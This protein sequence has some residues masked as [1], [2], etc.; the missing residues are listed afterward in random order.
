MPVT[1]RSQSEKASSSIPHDA[2]PHSAVKSSS[3]NKSHLKSTVPND[4]L[5]LTTSP[6]PTPQPKQNHKRRRPLPKKE[7]KRPFSKSRDLGKD[8]PNQTSTTL[9]PLDTFT[10]YFCQK[11]DCPQGIFASLANSCVECGHR[12]EDH[13][14]MNNPWYPHPTCEYICERSDLVH[15][16]LQRARDLRVVVIRSIPG[17]G[18]SVL[19]KL[20]GYH[21]HKNCP[22]LEPIFI[23][24]KTIKERNNLE[25]D[26]YLQQE[27]EIWKA[28]NAEVRPHN[29]EATEIF[30]IDE[31]QNSYEDNSFWNARLKNMNLLSQPK[32]IIASCL[33]IYSLPVLHES[34]SFAQMSRKDSFLYLELRPSADD[35]K[36]LLFKPVETHTMII[37]WATAHNFQLESGVSEYLHAVTDGHVRI[38]GVILEILKPNQKI[39]HQRVVTLGLC[40]SFIHDDNEFLL[41]MLRIVGTGFWT[42]NVQALVRQYF[43]ASS[44]YYHIPVSNIV[45]A[46]R[47]VARLPHGYTLPARH[48]DDRAL[49]F[50]HDAGLL[51]TE[52]R[53]PGS[54]E[55]TYFFASPIHRTI[56]CR[57]LFAASEPDTIQ[58]EITLQQTCFNAIGRFNLSSLKK[59]LEKPFEWKR[60]LN[61]A[62][63]N[64]MYCCLNPELHNIEIISEYSYLTNERLDFYIFEKKWGIAILQCRETE[65]M[66]EYISQ[67]RVGGKYHGWGAMDDFIILTFWWRSGGHTLDIKDVDIQS[68]I[69]QVAIDFETYTVE[70]YTYDGKLQL[71][72]DLGRE[73][74]QSHSI[75]PDTN[76]ES[77]DP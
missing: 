13:H 8:E 75:G 15:A 59:H 66:N 31:G 36:H 57:R 14:D 63:Q 64:E 10:H 29:P 67:F 30:L 51:H 60:L 17:V 12:F 39:N 3:R 40:Y 77:V 71:T 27:T 54:E 32:F 33:D 46:L 20:L 41:H 35:K 26:K 25:Y 44:S 2:E 4:S 53:R 28:K 73:R 62:I 56:A 5:N 50:C 7:S 38:L 52:Q 42:P 55:T 61:T 76:Q 68:H 69:L 37:K 6:R 11:C 1:T 47:K 74:Q 70:L 24:W 9:S 72:L 43:I 45:E 49:T 48:L 19:L 23:R 22:D 16:I 65:A 21:I 58:D 34:D 18:K